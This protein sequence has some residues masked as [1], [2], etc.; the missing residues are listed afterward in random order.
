MS[1]IQGLDE[2]IRK[3][4]AMGGDVDQVM[5]R[6]VRQ[7]AEVVRGTAVKLCPSNHGELRNS[8]HTLTKP[9]DG[10]IIGEIYTNKDY[11]P[12]VEFGT[13]P[14]GAANH[15]GVS[16]NV[17]VNYRTNSWWF[18]VD[19]P[20]DAERYGWPSFQTA[21][22]TI[23]ALTNGQAAQP[24]MYPAIKENRMRVINGLTGYLW[25]EMGKYCTGG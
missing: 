22:G 2:L 11:A 4:K 1:E 18:P 13:G 9:Q 24:F 15:S 17:Q 8:I 21:D 5:T 7:Q 10:A 20:A 3:F 25:R 14:I 19:D 16:P 6:G 23:L 12:Y